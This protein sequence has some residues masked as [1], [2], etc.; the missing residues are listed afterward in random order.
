M[1]KVGIIGAAGYTAG[2]LIRILI[3][4][5]KV[6]LSW[7]QSE[8]QAGKP[9]TDVHSDLIGDSDLVFTSEIKNSEADL[10][11]LCKGHGESKKIIDGHPRL[12]DLKI[13][14]LSHD[15]RLKGD[16]Q[17]VYGLP[18]L[19]REAIKEA[20]YVAN[21]GCF[22]TSI[23]L[24]LMPAASGDVIYGD[25]H[26]SG[27]TGSTG[28][29]QGFSQTSHFSWRNN[30]MSV[31]KAFEHQHLHEIG[32]TLKSLDDDF[33][34]DLNFIPYRGNFTRGIITTSYFKSGIAEDELISTYRKYY[35]K[36][37]FTHVADQNPDLK[38][39]VNTNKALVYPKKM[40][41][42][43]MVITVIDNLLKGASGQAVQNMNLMLGMKE[44]LA[45]DLKASAF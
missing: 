14:D 2:E 33:E 19:N 18:E 35:Q 30:N 28:A 41:E 27:I 23:Q 36:H 1:I 21:P 3:H 39:V 34:H 20:Q 29:G 32:E 5:P 26:I 44:S 43:V 15:Y 6:E 10:V 13:I 25:V 37:L 40:G 11:F 16:H 22:A 9:V 38:Q 31:Y 4:H 8:S 17:F 12:L 7:I 24:G 45:L 42:R